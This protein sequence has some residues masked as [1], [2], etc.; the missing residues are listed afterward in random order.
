MRKDQHVFEME[1][2]GWYYL[3]PFTGR[4]CPLLEE[5]SLYIPYL[6]QLQ[7]SCYQMR[8]IKSCKILGV[9]FIF[10]MRKLYCCGY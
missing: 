2:V 4:G 10:I 3:I 7:N 1:G 6:I 9:M 5:I 8:C